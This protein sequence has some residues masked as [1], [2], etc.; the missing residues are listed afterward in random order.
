MERANKTVSIEK[1]A[2]INYKAFIHKI[3]KS[4]N[5]QTKDV[6]NRLSENK[7]QELIVVCQ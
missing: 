3:T 6:T 7:A 2:A 1:S 5:M 4:R